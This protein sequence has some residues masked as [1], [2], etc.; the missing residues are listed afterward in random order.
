VLNAVL[1]RGARLVRIQLSERRW[2]HKSRAQV[3]NVESFV[4]ESHHPAL[5]AP[6]VKLRARARARARLRE[7]N[8]GTDPKSMCA[9]NG[10]YQTCRGGYQTCRTA[11]L[12]APGVR[13][14][15][16]ETV[17]ASAVL[18]SLAVNEDRARVNERHAYAVE[19]AA[20]S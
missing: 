8:S 17:R 9:D 19:A 4:I 2:T 6:P 3:I 11:G 20:K 13:T 18:R 15:P 1:H 14:R 10:G 12:S 16:S 7:P 5:V